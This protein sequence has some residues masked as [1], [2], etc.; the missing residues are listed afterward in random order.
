MST[1]TANGL[2]VLSCVVDLPA[3]GIWHAD[4]ETDGDEVLSGRVTIKLADATYVGTVRSGGVRNGRGNWKVVGGAGGWASTIKRKG[5]ADDGGVKVQ[6]IV[7]DAASESGETIRGTTSMRLGAHYTRN[8][9]MASEALAVLPEWYVA[10]D[11]STV[12]GARP[13][14][15]YAGELTVIDK[16]SASQRIVVA[17]DSVAR[18]VPGAIVSGITSQDVRHVL[19]TEGLR[20]TIWGSLQSNSWRAL[21]LAALPQLR[22]AGI[23]E[24]R[25]VTQE[26]D[27]LNLQAVRSSLGLPD[28]RRVSYSPGIPGASSTVALGS[29]VLVGFVNSDPSNPIVCGF[30]GPDSM[31]HMPLTLTM[32]APIITLMAPAVSITGAVAVTGAVAAAGIAAPLSPPVSAPTLEIDAGIKPI[33]VSGLTVTLCSGVAGVARIGDTV[34]VAVTVDPVTHAGVG[35]GTITSGSAKV[36]A[37]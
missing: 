29:I 36:F 19:T 5:Y 13:A 15:N 24:Y 37:G 17:S 31:G 8:E 6:T 32:A 1:C 22:Y 18:L 7:G 23:F 33:N 27:R 16:D 14:T 4:I 2:R 30:A 3:K 10:E 20:T 28:L 9:S 12:I 25:V 34:S 21:I 35:T 11:G 26:G